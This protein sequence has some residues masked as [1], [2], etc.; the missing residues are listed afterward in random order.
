MLTDFRLC[1][2]SNGRLLLGARPCLSFDAPSGSLLS[3]V[4]A[5][6]CSDDHES[7]SP[8][9]KVEVVTFADRDAEL[10]RLCRLALILAL[11][12]PAKVLPAEVD[13]EG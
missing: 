5:I 11:L 8:V 4:V 10:L 7:Q 13:R 12:F 2:T 9:V 1:V 6:S 3:S